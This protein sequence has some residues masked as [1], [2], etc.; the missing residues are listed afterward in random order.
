MIKQSSP[1]CS[2]LLALQIVDAMVEFWYDHYK[3]AQYILDQ[4][5]A[6]Y[7]EPAVLGGKCRWPTDLIQ[8]LR[9]LEPIAF[10]PNFEELKATHLRKRASVRQVQL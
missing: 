10:P 9:A 4:H 8:D 3:P 7:G 1:H 6:T 2:T 5:R